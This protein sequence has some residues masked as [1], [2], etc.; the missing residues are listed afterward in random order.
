V[1]ERAVADPYERFLAQHR[2]VAGAADAIL[3]GATALGDLRSKEDFA[4]AVAALR[5]EDPQVSKSPAS[6]QEVFGRQ[7][8][9]QRIDP[10]GIKPYSLVCRAAEVALGHVPWH[11]QVVCA[12]LLNQSRIVQMPNGSGKTLAA[13]LTA[14]F[15]GLLGERTHIATANDYLAERD[16]RWMGPLFQLLDLAAGVIFTDQ[17]AHFR[18]G[19]LEPDGLTL[20]VAP[21][22]EAES[23]DTAA[24]ALAQLTGEQATPTPADDPT[25][26]AGAS[27]EGP[28]R[29]VPGSVPVTPVALPPAPHREEL[30]HETTLQYAVDAGLGARRVLECDVVYGRIQGFAFSYLRDQLKYDPAD[31]VITHRDLLIVDECDSVLLDDLRTPVQLVS[32]V[33]ERSLTQ[34]T[35][36]SLHA[37]AQELR[38]GRHFNISGESVELNYEALEEVR[39][40]TGHDFFTE[41]VAGLAHALVNAL[42]ALHCYRA[43]EHYIIQADGIVLIDQQSGR[44]LVGNR[45]SDGLH[46][47]IEIKEG[48]P[49]SGTVLEEPLARITIKHFTRTYSR[50]A[51]MSGVVGSPK[52]YVHFYGLECVEV[53][54][55]PVTRVDHPD[56]VYR[57]RREALEH[58]VI[59]SAIAASRRGQPVLINVPTLKDVAEVG[60]RLRARGVSFQ[61]LDAHTVGN[62]GEEA[63]RIRR[64]G[65]RGMITI[66]SKVAARGTDIVLEPEARQAGGLYVSLTFAVRG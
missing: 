7:R 57:T 8:Q 29:L 46:A 49:V 50:V 14:G 61:A 53:P 28:R 31:Q 18:C 37:L 5:E 35:L 17:S 52:E 39:R 55:Y 45:Y 40:L 36:L 62:L 34:S 47:A 33:G 38:P 26:V 58:G 24:S 25:L 64:A 23:G 32:A 19:V 6:L 30:L 56:V 54:P 16:L 21:K 42:R 27:E 12:L 4:K 60:A 41:E 63:E 15:N 9:T 66:C 59:M 20:K 22:R 3:E 13:A 10:L 11:H 65:S 43:D 2:E 48:L 51:G 44:L 1:R